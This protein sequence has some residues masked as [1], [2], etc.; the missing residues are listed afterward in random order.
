MTVQ[1]LKEIF[2]R[3]NRVQSLG[4][5]LQP[6]SAKVGLRNT[7]GSGSSIV[8]SAVA[9]SFGGNHLVILEDKE[10]AAYVLNDLETF[11]PDKRVVFFPRS[12]RVPYQTELTEN[13]NIAMRAEALNVINKHPLDNIIVS[14]PEALTEHVVTKKHLAQNTFDMSIGEEY[15]MEFLDEVMQEYLFTKVD[16]VH[17][18]GEYSIRGGIVDIYSFS[19]DHPYRIEFFGDEIES[20]RK[21]DPITQLSVNKMTKATVVP[22]VGQKLLQEHRETFF[23][24]IPGDTTVWVKSTSACIQQFQKFFEKAKMLYEKAEG[25]MK[26]LPPEDLFMTSD[27]FIPSIERFRVVEFG[28]ENNFPQNQ[29][30]DFGQKPQPR[31]NKNFEMLG[32]NLRNNHKGGYINLISSG[33]PKQVERL[34]KIFEDREES[35]PFTPLFVSM[36]Q[37]FL[38]P[39]MKV[40]CYTDHEIF[41]RYHR[42]KLKEG[43]KKN[44]E[45]IT[46]KELSNLQPGDFVVHID[47]GIGEFSGLQKIDVNGKEQEAIRL[48]YKGG[49]ILYVSIHSLHRISKYS[50]KEGT[51]PK[52]NKL[53]T[54]AWQ[55][56]KNKTKKKVKELAFDLLKL[57][58]KR[59]ASKGF[60]YSP[61][62]YLQTELEASFIYEDTPDQLKATTAVKEDMEAESPM[63]RLICG[64]VGF[65]KTEIAIRAAFKAVTDNKQ[66]AVLVPTTI[67]SLQHY[68]SFSERLKEFP[69]RVDY[70]NRFKTGKKLKATLGDLKAGKVDILVGT[71]KL[72]GKQVEFADLGLLIIDEEQK[73]GVSVKDKL[74]TMKANVDTLTLTATP[75]PRTL[76]FSLMG[77]RDLSII[78][79]PPPN[80]YP[81]ETE[82]RTFNE[83]LIRDAVSYEISRGGQVYFVHNKIGNIKE[84][85]GMI[86]RLVPDTRVAIGHGQMDG[87]KLEQIMS[88]FIDGVYDVLVATTI[89]ESGIDISNANTMIINDA[90]NHGLSD[91]H[92]LRGRVGRSNKKAFCYLLA[93]PLQLISSESRKRLQA[94]EQFS[95]LGSGLN[96]AMRD[97]DIRGAGNMLG[98]EQSGFISDIGFD[99]YQ[100]ILNEA[101]QELREDEFKDL[102][103]EEQSKTQ[104]FVTETVLE[105]DFEI[106]IPDDYVTSISERIQLYRELDEIDSN[107]M[108]E[109]Y[110]EQMM[111]RFGPLPQQTEALLRTI[112][113]RWMAK[114]IGF[115]KVVLK[116][117]KMICYFVSRQDSPYY[118]SPK[119]SRV[120]DFVKYNP[121]LG[122]MYE[123]NGGLRLS[124]VEISSIGQAIQIFQKIRD[125]GKVPTS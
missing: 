104:E 27:Q 66:V 117:G 39:E 73:F 100:K 70:I 65:G 98:G 40:L 2:I 56:V 97:L 111:D 13:A 77:A 19:F 123:K 49:D 20:I 50:G 106:L 4:K 59:K 114:D 124:F 36:Y 87:D 78:S 119:F 11:L 25:L 99:M 90:H 10:E 116:S 113:L 64:D 29:I 80:R 23:E 60:A 38:D 88:D 33:Q 71:H 47:H 44:K 21:F 46:L 32:E 102:L 81:V 7:V 83:E 1:E 63:D 55:S 85:A 41:E 82:I 115:E 28:I 14:F 9:E 103:D 110:K 96:I 61:D 95:D 68:R 122:K 12:A 62:T 107:E 112:Q 121:R 5:M 53:G 91:L 22:N 58:A 31:F 30:L 120:L 93:P 101:M 79:T 51:A 52:I 94:L 48:T 43:F 35:A 74:K 54:N 34:T 3:N 84:V 109:L 108:L 125:A 69:C 8:M 118:Q 18:P 67:L 86:S 45:A 92:Q 6:A 24:F 75:I 37:G 17:E 57:Y 105:T 72:V 15:S 76:Q 42:F 89:I 16:Y 26:K